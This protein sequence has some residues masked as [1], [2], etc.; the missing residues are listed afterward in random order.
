MNDLEKM[1][2]MANG[3]MDIRMSGQ[4]LDVESNK[5]VSKITMQIDDS[6]AQS[7][8]RGLATD[9]QTHYVALYVINKEQFDKL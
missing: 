1:N 7:I 3:N 5:K 2:A 6:T 9:E 8:M 4:I